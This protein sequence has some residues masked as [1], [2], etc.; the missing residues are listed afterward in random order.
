LRSS[1]PT[2]H[3]LWRWGSTSRR[4]EPCRQYDS[5][6]GNQHKLTPFGS[7]S[8]PREDRTE[9]WSSVGLTRGRIPGKA[10]RVS[11]ALHDGLVCTPRFWVHFQNAIPH[12]SYISTYKHRFRGGNTTFSTAAG[13]EGGP[14]GISKSFDLSEEGGMQSS[15]A[16]PAYYVLV[17]AC[18]LIPPAPFE[19]SPQ[20]SCSTLRPR[21]HIFA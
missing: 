14:G 4:R 3:S 16:R 13:F 15:R 11:Q 7:L 19:T 9:W 6:T 17:L 18:F 8:L 5:S 1:E 2:L 10:P 21:W 20:S 12:P